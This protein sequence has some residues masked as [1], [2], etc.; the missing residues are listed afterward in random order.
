MTDKLQYIADIVINT[1]D[2][3]GNE[4]EAML[5][6]AHDL[7]I[8]L[9]SKGVQAVNALVNDQWAEYQHLAGVFNPISPDERISLYKTINNA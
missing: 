9:T 7:G 6:A 5:D 3:C 4:R 8:K 2:F 1:R